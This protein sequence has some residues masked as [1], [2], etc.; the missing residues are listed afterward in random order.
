MSEHVFCRNYDYLLSAQQQLF[1]M[2]FIK[3]INFKLLSDTLNYPSL[4]HFLQSSHS[5]KMHPKLRN[6]LKDLK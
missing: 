6:M 3:S 1:D 2:V 5:Q 4:W